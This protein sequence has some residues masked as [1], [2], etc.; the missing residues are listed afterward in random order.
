MDGRQNEVVFVA[1][2][3]PGF[4]AGG[5]RRVERQLCEKTLPRCI[6]SGDLLQLFQIAASGYR[7]VVQPLEIRLVPPTKKTY[8]AAPRSR[9]VPNPSFSTRGVGDPGSRSRWTSC[10]KGLYHRSDVLALI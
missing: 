5:L 6:P 10:L 9:R 7:V 8:L 1:Q 2:R 3:C 4:G